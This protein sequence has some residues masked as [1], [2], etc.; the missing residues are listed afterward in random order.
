MSATDVK[1]RRDYVLPGVV[2]GVPV[3]ER[4]RVLRRVA[5]V[6]GA[7]DG[8]ERGPPR[9]PALRDRPPRSGLIAV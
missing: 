3:D 1:T 2:G 4:V 8:R 5:Q 9:V 6:M 7:R